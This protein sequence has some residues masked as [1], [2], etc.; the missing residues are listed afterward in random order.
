MHR[1]YADAMV[2]TAIHRALGVAPGPLTNDL[3]DAAVTAGVAETDDL[4]WKSALPP[5]SG[6]PNTDFPKD[7]AA[8]ANSCGGLIVFGVDEEQKAATDRVDVGEV[9]E[10][11]ERT[12]RSAAIT[13]ISPPVFGLGIDTVTSPEGKRAVIV[14]VPAGHI[15]VPTPPQPSGRACVPRA[16]LPHRGCAGSA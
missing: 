12:L 13:A 10:T 16:R 1:S 5:A 8:M 3:L 4:D 2:F 9:S 6:V 7:V 15:I 11:Y 14:Q